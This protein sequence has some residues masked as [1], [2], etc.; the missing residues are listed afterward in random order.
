MNL[1]LETIIMSNHQKK[2]KQPCVSDLNQGLTIIYYFLFRKLV[3]S[4][5]QKEKKNR[6]EITF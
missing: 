4:F 1:D 3:N 2:K 5:T 6:P